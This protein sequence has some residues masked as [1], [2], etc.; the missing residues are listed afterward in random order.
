MSRT[1]RMLLFG[2]LAVPAPGVPAQDPNTT[3][4]VSVG[5]STAA[6]RKIRLAQEYLKRE[7]WSDAVSLLRRTLDDHTGDL[8][9]VG[10]GERQVVG[11]GAV[12]IIVIIVV[13]CSSGVVVV[14]RIVVSCSSGVVVVARVVIVS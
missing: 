13:S 1:V 11:Y 5:T 9:Q 12:V 7:D 8:V 14:A 3:T 4:T 2:L 6:R 10:P